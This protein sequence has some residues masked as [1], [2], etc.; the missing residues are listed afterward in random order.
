M[1]VERDDPLYA[2]LPKFKSLEDDQVGKCD[3]K[4]N[5]SPMFIHYLPVSVLINPIIEKKRHKVI[6]LMMV[7]YRGPTFATLMV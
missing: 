3:Y 1:S 6:A 5:S 2:L 4:G 7:S